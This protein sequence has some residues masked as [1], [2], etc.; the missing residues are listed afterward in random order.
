VNDP[1]PGNRPD[2]KVYRSGG[3]LL[4]RLRPGERLRGLRRGGAPRREGAP[5]ESRSRRALTPG[6]IFKYL[7]LAALAWILLSLVVFFVSAQTTESSGGRVEDVLSGGSSTLTGSTTLVLGSDARSDKT[8]EPGS[9]GPARSDS[10]LLLRTSLGQVR[11]LSVLRDSFAEIPGAGPQKINAAY[12]IGGPALAVRT[13]EGF[14]G[15]DLEINHVIEVSFEEFPELIDALGGV[16][17]KVRRRICAKPF[18]N[19]ERGFR[20]KKGTRHL[21]GERA[22]GFARV[23]KN[24]CAPNEDDRDRAA[25][26]QEVLSAMRRRLL[27][28]AAFVR[29]PWVSYAAP[30]TLRSDMRGPGLFGLFSGLLTGGSGKTRVLKPSDLGPGGSLIISDEEKRREVRRLLRG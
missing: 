23:R 14:L 10:I 20:L 12:A 29:L 21:N 25:R 3:G 27:S 15:N 4:D 11:R 5:R 26:Q 7:L 6:R 24:P 22:L 13:V 8:R 19:F 17:V 18:G 9:G 30:R 2:Y 1:R 16:N 28:P